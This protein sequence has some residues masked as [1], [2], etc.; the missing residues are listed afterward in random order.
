[1]YFPFF[2]LGWGKLR[3]AQGKLTISQETPL[4]PLFYETLVKKGTV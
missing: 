1:M 2:S 4:S 3:L